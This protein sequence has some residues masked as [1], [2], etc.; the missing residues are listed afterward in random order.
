[1]FIATYPGMMGIYE[2]FDVGYFDLIIA[3]ES[4]RSIYNVFGNLFK[5]FDC[6]QV[7]LTATPVEMV[8]RSTCNLFDCD[9][10]EPTANYPLEKAIGEGHL[11]P[12]E[13][14]TMTTKF[15]REGMNQRSLSDEQI[16][17]LEAQGEDPNEFEFES[18]EID[19]AVL[20]K[21]TNRK[22]LRNLME[23]GIK[24]KDNQLIGKSIIF[25]RKIN[26]AR[27]LKELFDEMYPELSQGF[28]EVIHS[29][30]PRA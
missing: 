19:N 16:A 22:I 29:E 5:Y 10:K 7:G 21:D 13:I 9:Y 11:V 23:N 4:H 3:D 30:E 18:A 25:A 27:L 26:H 17:E 2:D 28:C 15:M 1:M 24:D 8:S 20:N 6:L 12:F 14:V